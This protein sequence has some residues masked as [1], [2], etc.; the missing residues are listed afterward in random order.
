MEKGDFKKAIDYFSQALATN[1][2][3]KGERLTSKTPPKDEELMNLDLD[4]AYR[5][6]LIANTYMKAEYLEEA[7][8]LYKEVL[9][10]KKMYL[11][12]YNHSYMDSEYNLALCWQ[13]L[14]ENEKALAVADH[15]L[16]KMNEVTR[17][18]GEPY[19]GLQSC[20][21]LLG[22]LK[23]ESGDY[24]KA[25][26]HY[27]Q[28][29]E[30]GKAISGKDYIKQQL[31]LRSLAAALDKNGK[32][33]DAKELYIEAI[34]LSQ[35]KDL[36]KAKA[37][38]LFEL[39]VLESESHMEKAQLHLSESL[40]EMSKIPEINK[41]RIKYRYDY[42]SAKWYFENGKLEKAR[43]VIERLEANTDHNT[44]KSPYQAKLWLLAAKI[45]DSELGRKKFHDRAIS[46]CLRTGIEVKKASDILYPIPLIEALETTGDY[47]KEQTE[48][49]LSVSNYTKALQAIS[50]LQ[51]VFRTGG[52]DNEIMNKKLAIREKVME[53]CFDW[54]AKKP[55]DDIKKSGM[56]Q[57]ELSK[58]EV[59]NQIVRQNT[60]TQLKGEATT[61]GLEE[62]KLKI[63]GDKFRSQLA[64]STLRLD[65]SQ[66]DSIEKLLAQKYLELYELQAKI[67]ETH[68]AYFNTYY[69]KDSLDW[70][71]IH[72][73]I[74]QDE[75]ILQYHFTHKKIYVSTIT[76]N[77][78]NWNRVDIT[79]DF[80]KKLDA[81]RMALTDNNEI[82]FVKNAYFL[83]Q[84][85]VQPFLP[86]VNQFN[87]LTIIPD[88]RISDIPF[89]TFLTSPTSPP[90]FMGELP[91]L[92]HDFEIRY[93]YSI[94][95]QNRRKNYD[96]KIL[97]LAP[98]YT[99]EHF[100]KLP[101]ARKEIAAIGKI[102]EADPIPITH[103]NSGL[104]R[105]SVDAYDIIHFAGHT[106]INQDSPLDSKLMFN[107]SPTTSDFLA[108]Y[109]LYNI[110]IKANLVSLSACNGNVGKI[111]RGQGVMS[112][113]KGFAYAG[114]PATLTSLLSVSD[115]PTSDIMV[116]FYEYLNQGMS[117]SK[118][119]QQAKK[120]YLKN[121][122]PKTAFPAYWGGLILIGDD[123]PSHSKE[124][125]KTLIFGLLLGIIIIGIGW[126]FFKAR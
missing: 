99:C 73:Q 37:D 80:E 121:A 48:Y 70:K 38:N 123:S 12:E 63:E 55:N 2:R 115:K 96:K 53:L 119:L 57:I 71:R 6:N 89:E 21:R 13:S 30:L 95:Q 27:L 16:I 117:K 126:Y 90:F 56:A 86:D 10:T 62:K 68:P 15:L 101:F 94:N 114:C 82:A 107:T 104:L 7:F 23:Y 43:K 74:E 81:F 75:I 24:E 61:L 20:H 42:Y 49:A 105:N 14:G 32:K 67:K 76:S 1:Y 60:N 103:T 46:A 78:L 93:H 3:Y 108:A 116:G 120:D 102:F 88:A 83:Y 79:P 100:P 41:E 47:Y 8:I 124:G 11:D 33:K 40:A 69:A 51:P 98:E 29:H 85:L 84:K 17:K 5:I 65:K 39:A 50:L 118:A 91:F 52:M 35:G 45:S 110:P 18:K 66:Q 109:E 111:N 4:I 72:R 125:S 26:F 92:L 9:R 22:D 28:A 112:L 106:S 44:I 25:E 19:W 59:L 97:A 58:T 77:N 54:N 122:N 36:R 113:A 87:K 34:A 64:S 31:D